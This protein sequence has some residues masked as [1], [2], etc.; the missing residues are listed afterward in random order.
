MVRVD[1]FLPCPPSRR[2]SNDVCSIRCLPAMGLIPTLQCVVCLCLF[3]P[4]CVGLSEEPS[5]DY[6]CKVSSACLSLTG[7]SSSLYTG[8]FETRQKC[9]W[10]CVGKTLCFP[11]PQAIFLFTKQWLFNILRS[12]KFFSTNSFFSLSL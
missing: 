10:T 12:N 6:K 4:Q 9:H 11:K 1:V 5:N 8:C 2:L 7:F 3:H